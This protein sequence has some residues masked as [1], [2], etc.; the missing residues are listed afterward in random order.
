MIKSAELISQPYS[1]KYEERIYDI[2]NPWNS[3]F[4]T[5]VKFTDSNYNE[6]CGQFRGSPLNVGLSYKNAIA[7]ILTSDYLFQ[8]DINNASLIKYEDQPQYNEM[9]ESPDG[10]FI[11]SDYYNIY[12]IC[13]DIDE[14]QKIKS[15]I[16]MDDIHFNNWNE[17]KLEFSCEEFTAWNNHFLMEY[18]CGS[19]LIKIIQKLPNI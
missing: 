8:L 17:N 15:P 13:K 18:D 1:G 7:L 16:K 9:T 10:N 12:Q 4:W 19:N 2:E 6:W 11:L 5:W 14:I 3:Q